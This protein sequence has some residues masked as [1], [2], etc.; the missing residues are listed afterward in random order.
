M[1]DI[2]LNVLK[3][4]FSNLYELANQNNFIILIPNKKLINETMLNQNFYNN[5]IF[6]ICKYDE[7]M[8]IN[9][10]GKVLKYYHP[11]FSSFIGWK[12][13]MTFNIKENFRTDNI[14]LYLIDNVC[15]DNGY[16]TTYSK[17]NNNNN[18]NTNSLIPKES[19]SEYLQLSPNIEFNNDDYKKVLI[20]IKNFVYKMKNSII[21]M[22]NFEN[23]YS[24]YFNED[25][26]EILKNIKKGLNGMKGNDENNY[27]TVCNQLCESLIFNDLYSFIMNNLINFYSEDEKELK[28]KLKENPSRFDWS[29]LN[30]D[31]A[32]KNCKFNKEIE[33]L[34][35]IKTKKTVFEK[36]NLIY[37]INENMSKEAKIIYEEKTKKNYNP[38][39]DTFLTFWMYILT[40]S[41]MENI[42]AESKFLTLFNFVGNMDEK[43]Y[44]ITTFITAVD[45]IEKEILVKSEKLMTQKVIPCFI[46]CGD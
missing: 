35:L 21:F 33:T 8:Y 39:A 46:N 13:E 23:E 4:K 44:L 27:L 29:N 45:G 40:H 26:N 43:S 2:F 32:F 34:N 42:I 20:D 17:D 12:K 7:Q 10:N 25:S 36:A 5:H 1:E 11:K 37:L 18:I 9:L 30:I 38:Q 16:S 22:K 15:D 3:N 24:K 19:M 31:E 14:I 6:S 41:S 28:K